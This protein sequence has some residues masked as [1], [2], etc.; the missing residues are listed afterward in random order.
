MV[1]TQ[2]EHAVN[3]IVAVPAAT[4]VTITEPVAGDPTV[5]IA[6]LLLLHVPHDDAIVS[7]EVS[8]IH[9]GLTPLITD[10]AVIV[11]VVVATA[12]LQLPLTVYDM[13]AVPADIPET[14]PDDAPMLA[15]EEL[16]LLHTPPATVLVSVDDVPGQSVVVP[17]IVPTV[18]AAET[19]TVIVL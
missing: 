2:P 7:V 13:T 9:A 3:D 4:P 12:E 18:G 1:D 16:L 10:D 11:T 5:A 17:L 19:V 14:M 8:P 6:V 15:T